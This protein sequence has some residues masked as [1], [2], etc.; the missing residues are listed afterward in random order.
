MEENLPKEQPMADMEMGAMDSKKVPSNTKL[1]AIGVISLIVVVLLIIGGVGI[2][3]VY[4]ESSTGTLAVGVARV[5]NLPV[6]RVGNT[7]VPYSEYVTDRKALLRMTD[8]NATKNDSS[9][10]A[11]L[12]TQ[13]VSNQV[14]SRLISNVIIN[15]LAD[16]YSITVSQSEIDDLKKQVLSQFPTTT[17]AEA[18]L[19]KR[20]GWDLA[21]YEQRVMKPFILQ[22]KLS[23]K[24]QKDEAIRGEIKKTASDVLARIK[25]GEKFQDLAKQ[26]GE[27]AT[28]KQGGDLGWFGK[29]VMVPEFEKVVFSLKKGQLAPELTESQFGYHIIRVDDQ[30]TTKVKNANGKLVNEQQVQASH[31]L[32]LYPNL[33]LILAKKVKETPVKVYGKLENPFKNL[34]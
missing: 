27:D 30:R 23:D 4:A 7:N 13:D 29:G 9:L 34:P 25:K 20:F 6:A 24:I 32:F 19:Q 3:Q 2:Y 14:L 8:Y 33:N 22:N 26:F 12:S 17:D 11:P 5:L 16:Q 1:F 31:I 10:G 15:S 18:D 28:A 21:T